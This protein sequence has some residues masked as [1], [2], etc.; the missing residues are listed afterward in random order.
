MVKVDR[1]YPAPKSLDVESKKN[2]GVYNS[3]DVVKRLKEDFHN[4]CYICE[5]DDLQDAV[6][7]HLIPHEGGKHPEL[8]YAWENLFWAC[9]HCNYVKNQ[10]KYSAGIIDCCKEDPEELIAFNLISDNVFVRAKDSSNAKAVLTAEL[11]FE[12]FNRKNTGMRTIASQDRLSRLLKE[13]NIFM[14]TLEE[15][16]LNKKS[17]F[18]RTRLKSMLR[19]ESRFA[20]FKRCYIRENFNN[21]EEL[22]EFVS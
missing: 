11:I 7:E 8:K 12:V 15:W 19:R 4:K 13:M 9:N 16:R 17:V 14:T 1:S 20:A 10:K 2:D 22:V 5:M 3:L 18:I 21:D 6:V